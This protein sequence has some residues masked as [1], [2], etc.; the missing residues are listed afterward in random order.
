[1]VLNHLWQ[2][3]ICKFDVFLFFR[4]FWLEAVLELMGNKVRLGIQVGVP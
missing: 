3:L 2:I 1:M 4:S